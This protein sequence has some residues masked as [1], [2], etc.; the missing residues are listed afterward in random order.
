MITDASILITGG[1]GTFGQ[2][3]VR[4]LLT[5]TEARRVIVYSR[6]ELKQY[7]Q[8]RALAEELSA[9][10]M[11]R[12]RFFIGDVRDTQRLR[13]AL[14]GVDTVIHAAAL[15]QVPAAEYNPV[16]VVKTNVQGAQSVIEA[17]LDAGV[18]RVMAL[19]TDKAV[20]PSNL[21]G[22]SKMVAEKLFMGARHYAGTAGPKFSCCRYG[23]VAGSRGSVLPLFLKQHHN[24]QPLTVTDPGMTRFWMRIDQAVD[25]VIDSLDMQEGGDIFVPDLPAFNVMDLA[26]SVTGTSDTPGAITITGIRPGE[27]LHEVLLGPDESRDALHYGTHYQ[28]H[29][30]G[31]KPTDRVGITRRISEKDGLHTVRLIPATD[32]GEG[33]TL[34]SGTQTWRLGISELRHEI[35]TVLDSGVMGERR[36]A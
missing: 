22:A 12:L 1:T 33:V 8:Q 26:R 21:Y 35:T 16:E 5:S 27:K 14:L 31:S 36:Y 6:D 20:N 24:R 19:S 7:E 4:H 28:I 32:V 15:K 2:A 25:F 17:C 3:M 34:S 10:Q 13:R 29:A 30:G 11:A 23:N 9:E 18:L